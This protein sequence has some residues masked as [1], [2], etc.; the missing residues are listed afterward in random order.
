VDDKPITIRSHYKKDDGFYLVSARIRVG[1]SIISSNSSSSG[2]NS[3]SIVVVV[4]VV[5]V[6]AAAPVMQWCPES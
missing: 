2:S 4:V 5:V 3:S 1:S 6:V